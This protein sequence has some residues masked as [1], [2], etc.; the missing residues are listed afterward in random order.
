MPSILSRCA[1][2]TSARLAAAAALPAALVLVAGGAPATPAAATV[3]LVRLGAPPRVPAGARAGSLLPPARE[4]AIGLAFTPR[5]PAALTRFA[6]EVSTP[7]SPEYRHRITPAE[8]AE[9]FGPTAA[10]LH[11]AERSLREQGFSLGSLSANHLLLHLR[12]PVATIDRAWSVA[13]RAEDLAGGGRGWSAGASPLLPRTLA[14]NVAAVLGLDQLVSV[15][16]LLEHGA[17]RARAV[18]A[19]RSS[20][21][22]ATGAAAACPA[23]A[24]G[25]AEYGGWTDNA[26]ARAYGLDGLYEQGDLSKGVTIAVFELE[27]Y[28]RSDISTFDTCYFGADHTDQITN[29]PVDGG[30][31]VGSGE[32]EAV[33]DL[34]DI[35]A[36]APAAKVLV[37]EGNQNDYGNIYASTDV[38][39]A[40]VSQDRANVVSTSWGL[41]ETALNEYA[42]GTLEVED[43]LFEEAAAQ[44]Q[45]VFAAAGDD[46]SDDCSYD[47]ATPVAPDLSVDDPASQPFVVGAGGTSLLR[48]SEPPVETVWNDGVDGGAG[49]GGLSNTWPSPAWQAYSGVKG[50]ANTYSKNAA[51]DFCGAARPAGGLPACREVPD[52]TLDADEY[53]GPS[54]YMASEGDWTTFG[55]TSSAAPMW[56]AITA[57]ISASDSCAGLGEAD[58]SRQRDLGFVS[59]LLYEVAADPTSDASSFNDI[60]KG[61][62][63]LYDLGEGYPATKGYDLASGLGSPRVTGP[64]G[65]PGLAAA[66]CEAAGGAAASAATPVTVSHLAPS[67]G[68]QAGGTAVTVTGTGFGAGSVSVHFGTEPAASVTVD[69]PTTLTAVAPAAASPPGTV[70]EAAGPVDVTVTVAGSVTSTSRPGPD[71]VFDYLPVSSGSVRPAVRGVGPYGGPV[72]GG[73]RVTVYG[74]GFK[75]AGPVSSVTFGTVPASSF[76]VESNFRLVATVPPR[77]SATVCATGAGFHPANDCQ[78]AVVVTGPKGPSPLS[79]ILPP[80]TGATPIGGNGVF[81]PPAGSEVTPGP[82][83]Y[84]YAPVPVVSRITPNPADPSG[85]R[86]ITI[87]GRGFDILTFDWVYFGRAGIYAN[88]QSALVSI[89]P[90]EIVMDPPP[91]PTGVSPSRLAGGVSVESLGGRSAARSFSYAGSAEVASLSPAGG[92]DTGGETVTVDGAGLGDVTSIRF[93]GGSPTTVYDVTHLSATT[94]RFVA[95]ADLPSVDLV[96]PCTAAGCDRPRTAAARRAQTF[97]VFNVG[98]PSISGLSPASGRP[99][100]G[101]RVTIYGDNLDGAT[102][103]LFGTRAASH[104]QLG[105]SYPDGNPYEI[106]VIDPAGTAGTSVTVTVVTGSGRTAPV[107]AARFTYRSG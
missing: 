40:I 107:R 39:N 57:E 60:T 29:V 76:T 43:Y 53:R 68:D 83:E 62:N 75:T 105:S 58:A 73:N 82:D 90:D 84:D 100:G 93:A 71:A 13:L 23:A 12:A 77:S 24:S 91:G 67:H 47:S 104:L 49:G 6:T 64:E 78:V 61:S 32:G 72:A 81:V 22:V 97:V 99:S 10:T 52:V 50:V 102:K 87:S 44:G 46:G 7:G 56:A 3:A 88:Q 65:Q 94:L 19:V 8:F 95:P 16:P 11:A 36:L 89:S 17:A 66:L 85:D 1:R 21:P 42:P 55:G 79:T 2:R 26:M 15:H 30:P 38:Y 80:Y 69:S 51:Y 9:R 45:T 48:A 96:E 27:P 35:S 59:P 14:R 4:M 106:S 5:D 25:A 33:L 92:P 103:V 37:Y 74:S 54:V 70:G 28:L 34:D 31:G 86:P 41:C 98:S 101:E 63:D 18:R 20:A